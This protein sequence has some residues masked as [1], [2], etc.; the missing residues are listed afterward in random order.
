MNPAA[1]KV[2]GYTLDDIRGMPLHDAIHYRYPDGSPYPMSEC[3]IDNAQAD[4]VKM[5]DYE[6]VFVRKDGS[7]FPVICYIEPLAKEGEVVGAVLEFQ[8][9]TERKRAE[10]EIKEKAEEM[11]RFTYTVSHDLKSPLITIGGFLGFLQK[12]VK[13]GATE[14]IA[15]DIKHITGA[16]RKMQNLLDELLELSRIGRLVNPPEV[17]SITEMATQACTLLEGLINNRGVEVEITP[18]MPDIKCDRPRIEEVLQNLIENAVKYMGDQPEPRITIG[19]EKE[20]KRT[21]YF[22]QD[23]GIG[24]DAKYKDRVFR[25]FEKLDLS[26]A[27]TGI[28]LSIVKR[29]IEV[30]GGTI[31]LESEGIGKGT[32]FYF[33]FPE[34]IQLKE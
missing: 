30:H 2:T 19:Y 11:E 26:V 27:G 10:E 4:L 21:V 8:D 13:E 31:W 1:E 20:E 29:I 12:D 6:D 25:I 22:V 5:V 33:T 24:V 28:G 15:E 32:T 16:L 17:T 34:N 18:D 9:I 14:K 3:P 23:N 7:L